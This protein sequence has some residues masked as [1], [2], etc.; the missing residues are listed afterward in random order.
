MNLRDWRL[1]VRALLAPRRV[2]RELDDELSF[3]IEREIHELLDRGLSPAEARAQA[4][5][6][7]GPLPLAADD[8]RDARGTA[9]VENT[10]RDLLYALRTFG[11]APLVASTIVSTV[12]IGLSLVAVAFTMLN[13]M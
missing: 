2:E 4:L 12:A 11:R 6:R 7:F 9:F 3:H 13:A 10:V 1:R 5:A 8:C